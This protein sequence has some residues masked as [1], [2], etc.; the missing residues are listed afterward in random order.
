MPN[1]SSLRVRLVLVVLVA[2]TPVAVFLSLRHWP[3]IDYLI[4]LLPLAAAWMAFEYLVVRPLQAILRTGRR[5]A[6]GDLTARSG[7]VGESPE[8]TELGG[9]IDRLASSAEQRSKDREQGEQRLLSR[10]LEQSVV[11]A[12]GQFALV[13]DDLPALFNQAITFI[14]ETLDTE[15]CDVLELQ[16]GGKTMLLRAGSGWR[17]GTV[18]KATVAADRSNLAGYTLTSGEPVVIADF[19][20]DKRFTG[21]TH[22]GTH[23][24]FSGISVAIASPERTYGVLGAYSG[25][26]R[27]FT[28]DDVQFLVAVA[29]A[30]ASAV[31]R[32][33]AEAAL[34]KLA[35]FVQLYPNPAMEITPNGTITYA[36]DATLKLAAAVDRAHSR[37]LLPPNYAMTVSA[38]LESGQTQTRQEV[39]A[40]RTLS[41]AFHPVKES[42]VVHCYGED[43]TERLSLE[44]QLRQSQKIESV[45]H[46]AAGV[47]HDF[48]NMLTII[49]GHV[50]LL[51]ARPGFPPEHLGPLQAVF[52]AS[53]RAA[54]LTRQLLMFSR[55]NVMQSTL[56]DVREVVGNMIK[57]LRRLIG[58]TIVVEFAPP[59]EIPLIEG[60]TGMIDQVLMNLAIN[61]R[62]A[63]PRGGKLR[64]DVRAIELDD[65]ANRR[66]PEARAGHF[67]CLGVTDTGTGI[68]AEVMR[69]IFEPFFTTKEPG[70]GTGLG[71]ATVH[72]II[73]QHGGWIE[74]ASV[75]GR[76]TS[77]AV[78]LPATSQMAAAGRRAE[79]PGHDVQGGSETILAVEDEPVLLNLARVILE[80]CGYRV[81]EASSGVQALETWKRHEA[82]IDLLLTDI[83]MPLGVSGLELARTL[84]PR[85]PGLKVIY[86]SG[87][88]VD[89]MD[90]EFI[91]FSGGTFLQKPYTR[92]TLAKAVRE[93][94]D[95]H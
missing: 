16:P 54:G 2:I 78:F 27:Q 39:V 40:G 20:A 47:A 19:P 10:A 15:F 89:Q 12:L 57:M 68:D 72:G 61:A 3:S 74:V 79:M 87:Y 13:S 76:G 34:R 67:V 44:E 8:M 58:E 14:G 38:C 28:G 24:V 80:D 43:I 7:L 37:E 23:G 70:K 49:H 55:K 69:H 64:I 94:L 65:L 36:N 51:M 5:L 92:F 1:F 84:A 35:G 52:F 32:Q 31:D 21:A 71:L 82:E 93:S 91:E 59:P 75:P 73:K 63:M 86:T 56:L 4:V 90:T 60:D 66:H 48:N 6:G 53:E 29:N 50:G 26:A 30:I 25:R 41:W 81:L 45:G 62:D 85:K 83:V 42:R 33:N 9:I 18:G 17:E 11:A 46:L 95:K 77:F 22:L 88:G